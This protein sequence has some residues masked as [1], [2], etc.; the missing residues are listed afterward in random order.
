M[1]Q[2]FGRYGKIQKLTNGKTAA[3]TS[4]LF[5][6]NNNVYILGAQY[7]TK[8][9]VIKLWKNGVY[10]DVTN[11][12]NPTNDASIFVYKGDE[13]ICGHEQS[14]NKNKH[15]RNNSVAKIWK[16]G[17]P[18]NL[19]NGLND[20]YALS[21]FVDNGTTNVVGYEVENDKYIAK[22]WKNGKS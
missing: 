11:G 3:H 15:Y 8:N 9:Y 12:E 14:G 20:S 17:K 2:L 19:S 18:Q 4:S 22:L 7:N 13:Y 21:L 5:I 16:N 1:L 6:D 10:T